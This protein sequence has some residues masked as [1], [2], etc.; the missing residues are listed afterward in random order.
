MSTSTVENYLKALLHLESGAASG[1]AVSPGRLAQMLELT[2]GTVTSMV[3][4][5]A[6]ETELLEYRPHRGVRLTECG[7]REALRI[8]RRHRVIETFLVET[9]G[10]EGQQVHE[11]AEN[12]EHAMSDDLVERLAV[13][14]GQ[15]DH[16]P[17]G[18]PI[19]TPDGRLPEDPRLPLS[20]AAEGSYRIVA[21]E[22]GDSGFRKLASRR[23]LAPGETVAVTEVDRA[24]DTMALRVN[25]DLVRLGGKAAGHITVRAEE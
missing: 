20:E 1:A 4:R 18:A 2:P 11:E 7:R 13:L 16:D 23:R 15:P 5:L 12:L 14:L 21:I 6:R 24:A 8:L 3:K 19:P 17:H 10:L 9:V 25:G 22:G